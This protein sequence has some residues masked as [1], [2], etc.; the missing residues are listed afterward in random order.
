ML[1]SGAAA[2]PSKP[3]W[4]GRSK[5][6]MVCVS[7]G[8]RILCARDW[9]AIARI[10]RGWEVW[11]LSDAACR[12]GIVWPCGLPR[13]GSALAKTIGSPKHSPTKHGVV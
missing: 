13:D 10:G 6:A 5:A 9:W 8:E 7:S 3:K 1:T 4:K 12:G 11:N 2:C